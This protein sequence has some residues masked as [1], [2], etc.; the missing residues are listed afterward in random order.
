MPSGGLPA[1][2][3]ERPGSS[4]SRLASPPSALDGQTAGGTAQFDRDPVLHGPPRIR[5]HGADVLRL[6]PVQPSEVALKSKCPLQSSDRL[7]G[8]DSRLLNKALRT[9]TSSDRQAK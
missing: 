4:A 5:P 6:E 2:L 1:G 8:P 9:I 7:R 3:G